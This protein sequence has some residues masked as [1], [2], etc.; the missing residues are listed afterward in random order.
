MIIEIDSNSGFCYGVRKTIQLAEQLLDQGN[1]TYCVGEIVHNSEEVKRLTDK[2]MIFI[3]H[4]QMNQIQNSVV[5][6]RAHGESTEVHKSILNNNNNLFDGT[7]PIVLKLQKNIRDAWD[8]MLKVDGQVV[9]YGKKC[10]AEVIG[11]CGQTTNNTIVVESISDIEKLNFLKPIALFS[12]TTQS[13]ADYVALQQ[14]I[15]DKMKLNFPNENAPLKVKDSICGHVSK[16]GEHISEFARKHEVI[17]FVSGKN[18]SNGKVLYTIS[19]LHNQNTYWISG[20]DEILPEWFTQLSTVG[21]CGATST[22]HWLMETI[23]EK[24]KQL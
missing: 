13:P 18:S 20:P 15:L 7:C 3:D 24:I 9:I 23:K 2:G 10:H 21:I 8:E 19:K 22:P 1:T 5:L 12:Q 17:I 6:F 4:Q 16:R 14:A 11:L